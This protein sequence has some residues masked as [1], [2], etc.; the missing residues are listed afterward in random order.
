M[1]AIA[2]F[3][4]H[5]FDHWLPWHVFFNYAEFQ[6]SRHCRF[7]KKNVKCSGTKVPR[8]SLYSAVKNKQSVAFT[9][10]EILIC[11]MLKFVMGLHDFRCTQMYILIFAF[12]GCYCLGSFTLAQDLFRQVSK[13]LLL[14]DKTRNFLSEHFLYLH[15]L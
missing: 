1:F 14:S 11:P 7:C 8:I 3:R 2:H 13:Y 12:R 5:V 15:V 10:S 6:P 4:S 9:A